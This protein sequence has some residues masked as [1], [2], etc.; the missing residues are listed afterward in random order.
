MKEVWTL[1]SHTVGCTVCSNI[2]SQEY[3]QIPY[4]LRTDKSSY[5]PCH[6]VR[7]CNVTAQTAEFCFVLARITGLRKGV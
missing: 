6:C 7:V 1:P 5:S 2:H 4:L 3:A